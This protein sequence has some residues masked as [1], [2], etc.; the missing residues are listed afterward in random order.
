M[1]T[2]ALA[3]KE[4]SA[5]SMAVQLGSRVFLLNCLAMPSALMLSKTRFGHDY[6]LRTAHA[7]L[8]VHTVP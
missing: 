3:Y 8:E 4:R 1:E 2:V 5:S 7:N 6:L